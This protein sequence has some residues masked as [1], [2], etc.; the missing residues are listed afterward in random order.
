MSLDDLR[1]FDDVLADAVT[2][3]PDEHLP[4]V[5]IYCFVV[6]VQYAISVKVIH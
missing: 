5:R 4:V 1:C 6:N 2:K 3:H